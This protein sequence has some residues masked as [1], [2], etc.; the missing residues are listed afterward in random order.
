MGRGTGNLERREGQGQRRGTCRATRGA[1]RRVIS[2]K[3][4]FTLRRRK[5]KEEESA[6]ESQGEEYKHQCYAIGKK[7]REDR[8]STRLN[9]SHSGE[10]RMPS[11]A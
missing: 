3:R 6:T 10:S 2:N 11:S 9:S 7:N 4:E 8:K 1:R 5:Q